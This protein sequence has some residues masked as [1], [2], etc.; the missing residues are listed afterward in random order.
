MKLPLL[1]CFPLVPTDDV[2]YIA[3][4][5]Q[6]ISGLSGHLQAEIAE[7]RVAAESCE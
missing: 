5:T 4:V 2:T 3:H 7:A 6:P 1:R